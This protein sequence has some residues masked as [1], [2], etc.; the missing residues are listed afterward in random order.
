MKHHKFGF[1]YVECKFILKKSVVFSF[2]SV[3]SS[4]LTFDIEVDKEY[5]KVVNRFVSSAYNINLND[6]LDCGMSFM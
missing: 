3:F 4:S 1:L 5:S 2:S 6:W